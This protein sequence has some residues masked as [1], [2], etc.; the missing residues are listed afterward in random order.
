MIYFDNAATT[1]PKPPSVCE[2]VAEA[3]R[4]F[5]NPARG[6]HRPALAALR[7]I[8][9]AR[10]AIADMFGVADSSRVLFTSGATM[11]LNIAIGG[12]KGRVLVAAAGHNSVLRPLHRRG[13]YDV[14]PLD[15]LGRLDLD[16]V[17][18][19]LRRGVGALVM[20]HASNVCGTVYDIAR[21]GELCRR[22]GVRLVVDA[23]QSAGLLPVNMEQMGIS[24]LCF[25]GH[26][27]LYGPQGIGCLCLAPDFSPSPLLLGGSGSDS[28]SP[29][30]PDTLPDRLEAGTLNAHGVAGLRAGVEYVGSLGGRQLSE[31]NRLA[32]E[33]AAGVRS[34]DGATLYGDVDAA[35]RLPI[36]TLNLAGVDA[37]L[38]ADRL[39]ERHGIAV[40]SG[41]HCAPLMH[42]AY[43]TEIAGSVR[44][45][46][47]HYNTGDEI[48][49]ALDA[50][51]EIAAEKAQVGTDTRR[52][53]LGALKNG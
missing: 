39:D 11:A 16:R 47:S 49:L 26:K 15:S 41:L 20:A 23:A 22:R 36:V 12:L 44:F 29:L 40:R 42:R 38:V 9:A 14:M 4:T 6:A 31:A 52:N 51:R 3:L 8:L 50:L 13:G 24:A 35:V 18:D 30:P 32:R 1:L 46:F 43:G 33:F 7:E 10:T 53:D 17:E 34:I 27:S 2:A 45:S 37:A 25:S 21:A 28:L 48:A 5:G 19:F